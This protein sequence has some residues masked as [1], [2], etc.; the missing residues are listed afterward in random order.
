MLTKKMCIF[1]SHYKMTLK[2]C[3]G[4]NSPCMINRICGLKQH[5]LPLCT[6]SL[7]SALDH[8]A[9]LAWLVCWLWFNVTFSYISAIKWRDS[10]PVSKF[11]PATGHP[12]P[13]EARGL[14]RAEPSPTRT[15]GR[16]KTSFNSEGPHSVRV[17]Q[18][19]NPDL[20]IHN[21]ARYLYTISA[22]RPRL[23]DGDLWF[24][25]SQNNGM[26]IK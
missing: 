22:D 25:V 10:C 1:L 17:C 19:S 5:I 24:K 26:W 20:P 11:R 7:P 6:C 4:I 18:E 14:K 15:T 3:C 12:T 9:M 23:L 2:L 21:P 13:W 16:P 8:S